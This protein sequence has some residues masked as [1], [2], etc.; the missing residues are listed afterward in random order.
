VE[1]RVL[2]RI[3]RFADNPDARATVDRLRQALARLFLDHGAVHMQIG[4][5]YLYREGLQP[6][7]LAL[8]RALKAIVDPNGLINPGTLGLP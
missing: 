1:A 6:A 3:T 2:E 8:V 7:N 4:R 5:T